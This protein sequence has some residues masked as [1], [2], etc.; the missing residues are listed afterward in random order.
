MTTQKQQMDH[1]ANQLNDHVEQ[2]I[3]SQQHLSRIEDKL[4]RLGEAVVSI[5][6]AEEKIAT[7]VEDTR[8]IKLAINHNTKKIHELELSSSSHT[9]D[10]KTLGKFFWIITTAIV[11]IFA[12]AISISLG[13]TPLN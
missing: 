10:L 4:D 12:A 7:L 8:D 13:I 11:S 3:V 1:L 6:R 2:A 5:A 9:A